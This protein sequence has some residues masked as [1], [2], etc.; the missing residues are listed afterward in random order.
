MSLSKANWL[1]ITKELKTA[2]QNAKPGKM[3][4]VTVEKVQVD[5][6][7]V[8]WQCKAYSK[9]GAGGEKEQP[10]HLVSGDDLKR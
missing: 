3:V 4:T 9:D 5:S 8:H 1:H 7:N 10:K 6:V 2:Q